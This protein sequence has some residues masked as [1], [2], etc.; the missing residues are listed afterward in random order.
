M[1]PKIPSEHNKNPRQTYQHSDLAAGRWWQLSFL[2][3]MA[4]IGSE[5]ERALNWKAK[6][7]ADYCQKASERALEL[8]DLTLDS[9][10]GSNRLKELSRV[11]EVLADYFF[12]DNQYMSSEKSW[13]KYFFSFTYAARKDH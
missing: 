1:S 11:R 5:V 10:L 4:N 12:G 7:K 2:E 9:A 13:R 6:N 8:V 3:Q